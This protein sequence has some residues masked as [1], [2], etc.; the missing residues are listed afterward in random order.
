MPNLGLRVYAET[1]WHGDVLRICDNRFIKWGLLAA[2]F[3][4]SL[5]SARAE[6]RV[7]VGD[8]IEIFVARVPDLQRRVSVTLDGTI[9]FPLLG[10]VAVAG[11][12]PSQLQTKIQSI[13]ATK[14]F[15]QRASDGRE[16]EVAIDPDEVTASVVEYRPIYV[17]GDVSKPGEYAYRAFMTARQAVA[18]SGGFD[19]LHMRANPWARPSGH[20]VTPEITVFRMGEKGRERFLADEEFELQPGDVV[21][22]SLRLG[23]T[24]GTTKRA[25]P[26]QPPAPQPRRQ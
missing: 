19:P 15:Q 16:I 8:V 20:L 2:C 9:S 26:E 4:C 21:E 24:A 6:Y 11:L 14:V 23:N 7:D 12:S 13:L 18:M 22:V 3:L 1:L 17:N 10:S 25:P 5:V